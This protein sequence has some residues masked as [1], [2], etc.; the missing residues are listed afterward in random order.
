MGTYNIYGYDPNTGLAYASATIF[1]ILL[2]I[3]AILNVKFKS[4]FFLVIPIGSFMEV[5]GF[6][7]RPGA[8]Y[9][10]KR[11]VLSTL[12]ILLA[13]T[14]FAMADYTLISKL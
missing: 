9:D 8:A 13:P 2:L 12:G 11:Y 3:V 7:L 4:W 6:A 10:V 5:I 14:I 1:G